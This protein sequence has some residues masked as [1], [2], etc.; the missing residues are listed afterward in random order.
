MVLLSA[1]PAYSA[2]SSRLTPFLRNRVRRVLR[3][4]CPVIRPLASLTSR[5]A[6][7]HRIAIHAVK[8]LA[9]V[10]WPFLLPGSYRLGYIVRDPDPERPTVLARGNVQVEY[11]GKRLL[12]CLRVRVLGCGRR[13]DPLHGLAVL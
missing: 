3:P 7:L 6:L 13:N 8:Q 9:L 5:P 12:G 10:P 4:R 1:C 2:R 11:P